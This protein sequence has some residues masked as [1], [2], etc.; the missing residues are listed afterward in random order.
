MPQYKTHLVHCGTQFILRYYQTECNK[1][2]IDFS[3]GVRSN[4]IDF[5]EPA[6]ITALFGNALQNALEASV[7]SEDKVIELSINRLEPSENIVVVI[8]NSCQK[9]PTMDADG[10]WLTTKAD[11]GTHG[12]GMRSIRSVAAKYQGDFYS[13]YNE[14]KRRFEL[15][16]IFYHNKVAP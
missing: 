6:D 10:N 3:V 1:T 12:I 11:H 4:A 7:L 14:E 16:M 2:G 8:N 9:S 15:R 5:M 13:Q